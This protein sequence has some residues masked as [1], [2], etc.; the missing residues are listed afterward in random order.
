MKNNESVF[1]ERVF[2]S[3]IQN[4][5]KALIER[6][7]MKLWY[8]D[9]KEFKAEI[10]FI[11]EFTGGPSPEKQYKHVCEI[12]EVIHEKKLKYSWKYEG[13]EGISFVSFELMELGDHTKLT[14][15]HEGLE[16]FPQSNIDFAK[17]NITEGWNHIINVSLKEFLEKNNL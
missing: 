7:L 6:D 10:G 15:T 14:L 16:N 13:Y 3:S 11:F 4:V 12:L 2:E 1:I 8:F 5:W 17:E 9:L